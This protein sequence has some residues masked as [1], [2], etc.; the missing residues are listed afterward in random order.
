MVLPELILTRTSELDGTAVS[1]ADITVAE[2]Q[3]EWDSRSSV[4]TTLTPALALEPGVYRLRVINGSGQETVLEGALVLDRDLRELESAWRAP[5]DLN[6]E[7][8]EVR[9]ACR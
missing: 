7:E 5:L 4:R 1:G 6:G 3:V 8:Q 9:D 2:D